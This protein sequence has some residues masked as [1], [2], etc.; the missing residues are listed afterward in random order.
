MGTREKE[1]PGIQEEKIVQRLRGREWGRGGG[2]GK[3]EGA[4]SKVLQLAIEKFLKRFEN[5]GHAKGWRELT[6]VDN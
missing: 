1:L 6:M 2:A 3:P 5:R 4:I